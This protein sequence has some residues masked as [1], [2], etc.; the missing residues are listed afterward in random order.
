MELAE[1]ENLKLEILGSVLRV[2][3][4]RPGRRNALSAGLLDELMQVIS[5]SERDTSISVLILRGAGQAFCS[6]YDV[7]PDSSASKTPDSPLERVQEIEADARVFHSLWR[8]AIPA[9]AQ[10]HGHCLNAGAD[11]ALSCDFVICAADARIGYPAVR[12]MGVPATHMWLYHLGPQWA[13]VI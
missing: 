5:A 6:G 7:T 11:L 3:L 4:D 13:K 1:Y 8:C 2:T 9:L 10:V 12:S